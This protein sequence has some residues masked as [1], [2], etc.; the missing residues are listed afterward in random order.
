MD[1]NDHADSILYRGQ[2]HRWDLAAAPHL[3]FFTIALDSEDDDD[4]FE[5]ANEYLQ[6]GLVNDDEAGYKPTMLRGKLSSD[7]RVAPLG[8]ID[9]TFCEG[10]EWGAEELAR[11]GFDACINDEQ[12]GVL[13]IAIRRD[14][15][16][17][18]VNLEWI[19]GRNGDPNDGWLAI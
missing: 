16:T 12:G 2:A 10:E 7:A 19:D 3:V 17:E 13:T 14:R 5:R 11:R 15:L 8:E 4:A 18:V 1:S 9:L 6:F